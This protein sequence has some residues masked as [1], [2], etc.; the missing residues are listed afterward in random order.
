[1]KTAVKKHLLL[2]LCTLLSLLCIFTISS[3]GQVSTQV[4]T[5]G[6]F[7]LHYSSFQGILSALSIFF[8]ILMIFI[9]YNIGF[10]I[11][12]CIIAY[13]I[14]KSFIAIF[15]F[16]TLYP[17]PGIVSILVNFLAIIIIYGF[18]KRSYISSRTDLVTGLNNRKSFTAQSKE[19]YL[20]KKP[21]AMAFIEI[22]DFKQLNDIYGLQAG[23]H[24]LRK[25]AERLK[26]IL[27]GK[28]EVYK[29]TGAT[30]A[31]IFNDNS[32]TE[33][34]LKEI[35]LIESITF[36][37][38]EEMIT[39]DARDKACKLTLSIGIAKYPDNAKDNIELFK[40]ADTALSFAKKAGSSRYCFYTKEM[41]D[42]EVH[43]KEAELLI[44]QA[45]ENNWFYLVYQPQYTIAHKE[46]RGFETL[47]RCRKPDGSIVSP[48]LFIPAAEKSNLIL[49]IDDYV[50][51]RAMKEFKDVLSNENKS[52]ILSVNVSAK[53]ISSPSFAQRIQQIL[54]ET[55][56]PPHN[57]EIEITEYSL[58]ES[59]NTTIANITKLREL[60]VQIALDD[61]GTGYTSIAQLM[62]LPINLLKIDKSL[63]D[64]IE[65]N[66]MN[67]DLVDSV[68]YM[69]HVMNCDVIS[70]G[71][72]TEKQLD[73]LNQYHCDFVQGFVWGKPMDYSAALELCKN[74]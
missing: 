41:G 4:L 29:I 66:Q 36:I 17:L 59:V 35:M 10:K 58:A 74:S 60:G 15:K 73:V 14:T 48:A 62:K 8:C 51:R 39:S 46:L 70:E 13:S 56:F 6:T 16:H 53:N 72:E 63:I 47:I 18:Y 5:L 50:L 37:I 64:D 61:F 26:N 68:I 42:E 38:P 23:D 7:T 54:T 67:C 2:V 45:L 24:I 1:M 43:R 55:E 12:V 22:E 57:L 11:S 20:S 3:L 9:D 49:N 28:G 33:D 71:V 30:F 19:N 44:K 52:L 69:G 32:C 25:V 31:V 34:L 40:F 21:F 27:N 65:S